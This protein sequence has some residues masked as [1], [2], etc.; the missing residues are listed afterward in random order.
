MSMTFYPK[1][2]SVTEQNHTKSNQ[3]GHKKN[4]KDLF[5]TAIPLQETGC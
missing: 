1:I 4:I 2:T 5:L 3:T